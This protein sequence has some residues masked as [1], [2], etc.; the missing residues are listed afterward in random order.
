MR[1]HAVAGVPRG[2]YAQQPARRV[3]VSQVAKC[4]A[5]QLPACAHMRG[6]W[7]QILRVSMQSVKKK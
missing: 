1:R 7:V 5:W 3:L 2:E 6:G 4:S